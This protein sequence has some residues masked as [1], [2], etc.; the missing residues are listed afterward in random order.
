MTGEFPTPIGY[1]LRPNKLIKCA[2]PIYQ[3]GKLVQE[4]REMKRY[5]IEFLRINETRWTGKGTKQLVSGLQI[6]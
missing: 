4:V 5:K 3:T 6:L 2:D 1:V